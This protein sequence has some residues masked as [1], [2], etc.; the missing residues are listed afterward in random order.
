MSYSPRAL[1]LLFL[2]I[3]L[4]ISL[5]L[6]TSKGGLTGLWGHLHRVGLGTRSMLAV[7]PSWYVAAQRARRVAY[8]GQIGASHT[9]TL[10]NIPRGCQ[11][12][13]RTSL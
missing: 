3:P 8:L 13:G 11:M 2:L 7:T 4:S 6:H 1:S 12:G 10:T 5:L 9:L